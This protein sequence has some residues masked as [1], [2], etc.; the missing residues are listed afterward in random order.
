MTEFS[1]QENRLANEPVRGIFKSRNAESLPNI[2]VFE[3][4]GNNLKKSTKILQVND[5]SPLVNNI[6]KSSIVNKILSTN[7]IF[8]YIF[9]QNT[10]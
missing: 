6:K 7:K 10:F 2:T 1:K 3:E 8:A 4:F 5:R 9:P